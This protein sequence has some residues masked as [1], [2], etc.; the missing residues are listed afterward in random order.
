MFLSD[1]LSLHVDGMFEDDNMPDWSIQLP[2]TNDTPYYEIAN[3]IRSVART[4]FSPRN[5]E[6]KMKNAGN[7]LKEM[8]KALVRN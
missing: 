4:A 2:E 8:M 6:H 5:Q 3:L 1:L 7:F